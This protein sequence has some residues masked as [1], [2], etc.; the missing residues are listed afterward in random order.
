MI[1][2]ISV[3][4][5]RNAKTNKTKNKS[6]IVDFRCRSDDSSLLPSLTIA[7]RILQKHRRLD[8][9]HSTVKQRRAQERSRETPTPTPGGAHRGP[10]P[11][12]RAAV[13]TARCYSHRTS[14]PIG[15]AIVPRGRSKPP[16]PSSE[17]SRLCCVSGQTRWR[18]I[19]EGRSPVSP[20]SKQVW[21]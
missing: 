17:N 9:S 2:Q 1:L 5:R 14:R 8:A 21:F 19:S 11:E 3:R 4:G 6:S 7:V 20:S 15:A 18:P 13:W 12:R 16:S 10:L